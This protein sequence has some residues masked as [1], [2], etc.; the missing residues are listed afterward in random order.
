MNG[1]TARPIALLFAWLLTAMAPLTADAAD[2]AEQRILSFQELG[3][4]QPLSL[5]GSKGSAGISFGIRRDE[6]VTRARVRLTYSWSPSLV[7]RL[8][9]IKVLL[10]EE[11][12]ATLL[13]PAE[14]AGTPV[15]RQIELDPRFLSDFNHLRFQLVGHYSEG[16]QDPLSSTIW[17][18]ISNQSELEL[19]VTAVRQVSDLSH[20]PEPFFDRRDS[21]RLLLPFVFDESPDHATLEAA[22]VLASW[23]GAVADWRGARFPALLNRLPKRHGV[24]FA[25]NDDFPDFLIE[26]PLVSAPT[27]AVIDNPRNRSGKLLLILGRDAADLRE[28]VSG[29]VLGRALLSGAA[30]T[31]R[32]VE[33][34]RPRQPYDA[35]RWVRL[36][37]PVKFGELASRDR[38]QVR[39]HRPPPIQL[40]LRIPADLFTWNS[41]GIPVDL[42]YRYSPPLKPDESRLNVHINDQFVESFNLRESGRGGIKQRV[43]VPVLSAELFSGGNELYIPAFELGIRNRLRFD[44]SFAY[45]KSGDCETDLLDNI[46]AAIDEDSQIDFRG[47]PHYAELP[48]LRFFAHSGF[49]FTRLA[50]LADTVVVLRDLPTSHEIGTMLTVMGRMGEST[51]YPALRVR[52]AGP[53]ES[54][55][56]EE[57]DLMVIGSETGRRLFRHWDLRLDNALLERSGVVSRPVLEAPRQ[58]E[59]LGFDTRPDPDPANRVELEADGPLAAV[60]GFESPLSGKRSV[61]AFLSN[62]ICALDNLTESLLDAGKR[63]DFYGSATFVRGNQ[64][65]SI[66]SVLVGETFYVGNLPAWT[67]IWFH[68]SSHPVLLA[69]MAIFTVFIFAFGV[70]RYLRARAARRLEGEG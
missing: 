24:V 29:L 52:L 43:R 25:T 10:N 62:R 8:S 12:L 7:A 44:F 18:S 68:L 40:D 3:A 45:H 9:H 6:L 46:V 58:I 51:G 35:P 56:L 49:P 38:L 20:F 55:A 17:A 48:N 30:V 33:R 1:T 59:W 23:F 19:E 67:L 13:L 61:V 57:R 41:N 31:V 47:F 63:A 69:L 5:M 34:I 15:T 4:G 64:V 11:V 32:G 16:C 50:D 66:D 27:V 37:R 39:G 42:K 65:E 2:P 54:A 70:W 28:A 26:R 53:E 60:I 21:Q 22:A 14:Q 36:D